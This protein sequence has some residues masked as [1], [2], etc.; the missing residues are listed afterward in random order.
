[1]YANGTDNSSTLSQQQ[2]KVT[3]NVTDQNRNPLPGVTVLVK[4]TSTG[5]VTDANGAFSL[6]IPE[7]AEFL[8]FSFI[9]MQTLEMPVRGRTS[10]TVV[11]QQETIGLE[12]VVAVGY[13]TK[14]RADIT[15][16]ISV[17]NTGDLSQMPV[18]SAAAALQG[19]A[20]GVN[21]I[22]RGAPGAGS[23]IM[24]R[25]VTNFGNTDPLVIV[26]GV[27]QSLNN[28]SATDI[29]S[30][31]VLKDAGSAAIYGVRGANGVI[32]VTTK[33]GTKGGLV[34]I[35]WLLC[36]KYPVPGNPAWCNSQEYMQVYILLS[37]KYCIL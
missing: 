29:E 5:T 22:N 8:Q 36:M 3:G 30:I 21:V 28:I 27:E 12:E 18:R 20:S 14:R 1:M 16:S 31:Q 15:G 32:L 4:G 7:S 24:I 34:V 25:G 11:M 17:V 2:V 13:G 37:R 19:M 35:R 6:S 26:D 9:G 23:K 10:F 33:K